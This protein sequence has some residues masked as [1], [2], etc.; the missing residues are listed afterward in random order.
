MKW[1]VSFSDFGGIKRQANIQDDYRNEKKKEGR[2]KEDNCDQ[3][4]YISSRSLI[5][6]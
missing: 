1:R 2:K 6:H 3:L 5:T 4:D